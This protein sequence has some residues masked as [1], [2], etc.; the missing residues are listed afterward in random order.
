MAAIRQDL[1][2]TGSPHPSAS[3]VRGVRDEV[4]SLVSLLTKHAMNSGLVTVACHL[5]EIQGSCE[6]HA[7]SGQLSPAEFSACF[8]SSDT[9][10]SHPSP[11]REQGRPCSRC[12]LVSNLPA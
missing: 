5:P 10:W 9:S 6:K 3:A 2:G 7:D 12:G 1:P 4:L 11:Q 8:V